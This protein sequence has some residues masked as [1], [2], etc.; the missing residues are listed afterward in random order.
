MG[1]TQRPIERKQGGAPQVRPPPRSPI[2]ST[3][4]GI[5]GCVCSIGVTPWTRV[6][7]QEFLG[8]FLPRGKG[9][10][11]G[12][13]EK[14]GRRSVLP[15]SPATPRWPQGSGSGCC[16][17]MNVTPEMG[18][19]DTGLSGALFLKPGKPRTDGTFLILFLSTRW[20]AI[21][22]FSEKAEIPVCPLLFLL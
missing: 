9:G 20:L 8:G 19:T 22:F 16:A 7:F 11:A 3:E 14:I 13:T 2:I 1:W 18:N 6:R 17:P 15:A 21:L 10:K 4:G 12:T 5:I